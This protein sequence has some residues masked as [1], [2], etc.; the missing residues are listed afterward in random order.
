MK[1]RG[2]KQTKQGL[3]QRCSCF[4][5]MTTNDFLNTYHKN[6]SKLPEEMNLHCARSK[7]CLDMLKD[8]VA[9]IT[10]ICYHKSFSEFFRSEKQH[11]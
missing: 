2:E 8:V 11:S 10:V 5:N 9:I 1:Q 4:L 6:H 7:A 3:R